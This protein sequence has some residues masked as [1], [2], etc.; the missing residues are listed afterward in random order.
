MGQ[1]SFPK[2]VCA[3][4][5]RRGSGGL[6]P[7]QP[8]D[9]CVVS[10]SDRICQIAAPARQSCPRRKA[11]KTPGGSL[12]QFWSIDSDR[13][14]ASHLDC[15]CTSTEVPV[16][17]L[18]RRCLETPLPGLEGP[19]CPSAA[20]PAAH[21][22][23]WM[24]PS[25]AAASLMF[26]EAVRRM[27]ISAP[28]PAAARHVES[29]PA[30]TDV[31]LGDFVHAGAANQPARLTYMH[32]AA[33]VQRAYMHKRNPLRRCPGQ[34]LTTDRLHHQPHS[35][36]GST[37]PQTPTCASHLPALLVPHPQMSKPSQRTKDCRPVGRSGNRENRPRATS[38][39]SALDAQAR[40]WRGWRGAPLA[41][42]PLPCG[43]CALLSVPA[44][45]C[46][47]LYR[48]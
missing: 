1:A 17:H 29:H 20:H 4:E 5:W 15:A 45:S 13:E 3:E 28:L 9:S 22:T 44:R 34:T 40:S 36:T 37:S 23:A 10:S 25:P 6:G 39:S 18:A 7:D 48:A 41:F 32:N 43:F 33:Y 47:F 16:L 19:C 30:L 26:A 11:A 42:A 31:V 14:S 2:P 46:S 38:R 35:A 8:P 21:P 12:S 27:P 24:Q